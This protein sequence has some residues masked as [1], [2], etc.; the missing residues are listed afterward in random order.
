MSRDRAYFDP[1]KVDVERMS[2]ETGIVAKKIRDVLE[3]REPG[4]ID[5]MC[6]TLA[7]A[8]DK[9]EEAFDSDA[10][11]SDADVGVAIIELARF[12]QRS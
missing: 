6:D 5:I 12:F 2:A 11:K 10:V 9:L 8:K 4:M 3:G 7:E 1:A